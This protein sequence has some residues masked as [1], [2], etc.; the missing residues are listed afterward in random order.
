MEEKRQLIKAFFAKLKEVSN[1]S[2]EKA[3][4]NSE[5]TA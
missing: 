4:G 3:N 1:K 2:K 5:Q